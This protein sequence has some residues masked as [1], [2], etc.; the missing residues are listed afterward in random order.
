[1][2]HPTSLLTK[3]VLAGSMSVFAL[4]NVLA[5]AERSRSHIILCALDVAQ[6]FNSCIF[7]QVLLE[8]SCIVRVP[9]VYV[10]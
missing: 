1:M 10:L 4:M 2:S 5:D 9:S 7:H 8:T 6:A 3:K